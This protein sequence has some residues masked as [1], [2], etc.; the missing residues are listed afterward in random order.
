MQ[1]YMLSYRIGQWGS[2]QVRAAVD[3]LTWPSAGST[4]HGV[5]HYTH[6]RPPTTE[7]VGHTE[8]SSTYVQVNILTWPLSDDAVRN[9]A[10][11]CASAVASS[12][13]TSTVTDS[14]R[15][16]ERQLVAE[17]CTGQMG[18]QAAQQ[19]GQAQI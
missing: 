16:E 9:E 2:T 10:R 7:A 12:A 18:V 5:A 3:L 11:R 17:P 13:P 14:S 6:H 1:S 8:Q 19:Q 4:L 15:S